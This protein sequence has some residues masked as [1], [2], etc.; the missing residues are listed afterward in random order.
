MKIG[1]LVIPIEASG[2]ASRFS[3]TNDAFIGIVIGYDYGD[4]VV[5]WNENY[6]SEI[7]Y[8]EQLEVIGE[9]RR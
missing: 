7:E 2:K 5:Y 6:S 9:A 4:P 1:D 8:R 3:L